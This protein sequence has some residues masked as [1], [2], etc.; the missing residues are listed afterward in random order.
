MPT[1]F[2]ADVGELIRQAQAGS[3][4]AAALVYER[5]REPLLAVIRRGLSHPLRRLYDSDDFL[6]DALAEVFSRKFSADVL[7]SPQALAAYLRRIAEN[8]VRDAARKRLLSKRFTIV[9]EESF[10][11]ARMNEMEPCSPDETILLRELVEDR[12]IAFLEELPAV[13]QAIVRLVLDG[14]GVREIADRL[15]LTPL[16]VYGSLEAIQHEAGGVEQLSRRC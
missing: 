7:D 13:Y 15:H 12:L 9:L 1:P 11:A 2:P 16:R 14:R 6:N 10:D 5:C 8:K 4:E 3:Q